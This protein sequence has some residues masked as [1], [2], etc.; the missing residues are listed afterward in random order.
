MA[1]SAAAHLHSTSEVTPC[2]RICNRPVKTGPE[3]RPPSLS[4]MKARVAA[5]L[6]ELHD[7]LH[8]DHRPRSGLIAFRSSAPLQECCHGLTKKGSLGC[9]VC[10]LTQSSMFTYIL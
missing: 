4:P 9:S 7:L 2:I 8:G 10:R 5:A 1:V 3:G 6:E